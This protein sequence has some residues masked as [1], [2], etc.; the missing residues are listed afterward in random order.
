MI[1]QCSVSSLSPVVVAATVL[2]KDRLGPARKGKEKEEQQVVLLPSSA[3][4]H[5]S[6]TPNAQSQ[7]FEN[8]IS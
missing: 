8:Q 2:S 5:T 1:H 6:A 7:N 3:H 4:H